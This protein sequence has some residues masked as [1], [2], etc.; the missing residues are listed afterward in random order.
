MA[1]STGLEERTTDDARTFDEVRTINFPHLVDSERVLKIFE[2]LKRALGE[3]TTI[4]GTYSVSYK[5]G[6]NKTAGISE[7]HDVKNLRGQMNYFTIHEYHPVSSNF[8][9]INDTKGIFNGFVGL[10]FDVPKAAPTDYKEHAL[11]RIKET[12]ELE[13][14]GRVRESIDYYFNGPPIDPL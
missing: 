4:T 8:S 2:F 7:H 9:L 11:E 6:D 14:Y 12:G 3:G 1:Q 5:F 10:R 13:L